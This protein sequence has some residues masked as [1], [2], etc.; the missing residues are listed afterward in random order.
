MP[1][2][3][4][5]GRGTARR[6]LV[7]AVCKLMFW[8]KRLFGVSVDWVGS[9]HVRARVLSARSAH[10]LWRMA[11][12]GF[13]LDEAYARLVELVYRQVF[14]L[15]AILVLDKWLSAWMGAPLL[16]AA[17]AWLSSHLFMERT[18]AVRVLN[19]LLVAALLSTLVLGQLVFLV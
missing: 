17:G 15:P 12:G 19:A 16:R 9:S 7:L 5:V 3:N 14:V 10:N 2:S 8:I 4:C 6:R 11:W 13:W 18:S 1:C